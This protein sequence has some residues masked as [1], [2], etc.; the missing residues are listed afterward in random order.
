M[1]QAMMVK[2]FVCKVEARPGSFFNVYTTGDAAFYLFSAVRDG[3]ETGL[4]FPVKKSTL[5]PGILRKR[6][7]V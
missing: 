3:I 4:Q 1:E 6:A 5:K 2:Q 7:R